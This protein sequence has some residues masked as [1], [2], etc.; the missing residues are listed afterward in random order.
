MHGPSFT[1]KSYRHPEESNAH[2]R[3]SIEILK[4]I[5]SPR[6]INFNTSSHGNI[7]FQAVCFQTDIHY[8]SIELM[9]GSIGR[10]SCL[11]ST[12]LFLG[13]VFARSTRH[14]GGIH[15]E[16]AKK[17]ITA[18]LPEIGRKCP[19]RAEWCTVG[20]SRGGKAIGSWNP[21]TKMPGISL[22]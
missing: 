12:S 22:S 7:I 18:A 15:W 20:S 2:K 14:R 5:L 13:G 6:Y 3:I 10:I 9:A 21:V 1:I 19:R 17:P 16:W 8:F 4:F 11:F